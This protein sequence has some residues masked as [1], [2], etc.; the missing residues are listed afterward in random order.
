M[1]SPVLHL[2]F[3]G[4]HFIMK[5]FLEFQTYGKV[6]TIL[7]GVPVSSPPRLSA[8]RSLYWRVIHLSSPFHSFLTFQ[9]TVEVT[10]PLHTLACAL[11]TRAQYLFKVCFIFDIKYTHRQQSA[12]ML[13]VTFTE[14]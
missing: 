5:L 2:C 1:P 7:P 10:F 11:F 14:F 8:N 6:K 13:S 3:S 12:R 9:D 4:R